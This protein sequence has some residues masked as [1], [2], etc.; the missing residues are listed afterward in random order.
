MFFSFEFLIQLVLF[1]T[2]WQLFRMI[3]H[4]QVDKVP[5]YQNYFDIF[6]RDLN[7]IIS[8][9]NYVEWKLRPLACGGL[10]YT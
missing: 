4:I 9:S 2:L 10:P 8:I 3:F 6:L 7:K 1:I 5:I